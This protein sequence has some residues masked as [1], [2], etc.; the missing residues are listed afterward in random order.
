MRTK[1]AGG[2]GGLWYFDWVRAAGLMCEAKSQYESRQEV[3][4]GEEPPRDA[5]SRPDRRQ[6]SACAEGQIGGG[7]GGGEE[8]RGGGGGGSGGRAAEK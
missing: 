7:G 3:G 8:G 5:H 2:W 1:K 6:H 4:T